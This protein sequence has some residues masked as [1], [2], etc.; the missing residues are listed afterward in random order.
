[1]TIS[2]TTS[3]A[4]RLAATTLLLSLG[5]ALTACSSGSDDSSADSG[6]VSALSEP[7]ADAP[8]DGDAFSARNAADKASPEATQS[9]ISTSSIALRGDD[10]QAIRDDVADIVAAH[11][12]TIADERSVSSKGSL[13]TSRLVLR[14]PGSD[15][16]A[17]LEELKKVAEVE[18]STKKAEDVTTQ[19][20]DTRVRVAAQ[21]RSIKRITELLDRAQSIRDIMAIEAQLTR[22]QATLDSLQAQQAWLADQTSLATISVEINRTDVPVAHKEKDRGFLTGLSAGWSGLKTFVVGALTVLGAVLPFAVVLGFFA[23]PAWFVLR[24]FARRPAR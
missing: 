5:L 13:K 21:V 16:E 8:V 3:S 2:W 24:R 15:F 17:A 6:G 22:R 11:S 20:I 7:A 23:V 1:M 14:V 19:V 10:V 12:G 9:I 4:R 18:T